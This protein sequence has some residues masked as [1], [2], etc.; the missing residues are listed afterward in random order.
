MIIVKVPGVNGLG[1]TAGTR[2]A[3]NKILEGFRER[4]LRLEEIHVDNEDLVEQDELIYKNSLDLFEEEDRVIFLGGDHSVSYSIG[5]AFYEKHPTGKLIV[6]DAHADCMKPMK[7][8]THEEWLRAL[9]E[10]RD[11]FGED[12]LVIGMRKIEPEEK[13]F[14]EKKNVQTIGVDEIKF[15]LAKSLRKLRDFIRESELYVS[16]D[17]DVFDKELVRATH[18]R[19][20]AGLDEDEVLR[21]LD[22]I[23]EAGK[24]VK[25]FDLIEVNLDFSRKELDETVNLARKVVGKFIN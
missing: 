18:Y 8:P 23:L 4:D 3:G 21:L 6:F 16:F 20:E 14:L 5:S 13:K 24:R 25:G 19:E 10:R 22:V 7:E 1:H 15:D 11:L 9:I 17:I 12:V 2:N